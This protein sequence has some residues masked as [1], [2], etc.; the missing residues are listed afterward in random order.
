MKQ[1]DTARAGIRFHI[2]PMPSEAGRGAVK[3]SDGI[4]RLAG[5]TPAAFVRTL[6]P[7][8]TASSAAN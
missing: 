5:R 7:N 6:C 2:A 1:T 3:A 8:P 4:A